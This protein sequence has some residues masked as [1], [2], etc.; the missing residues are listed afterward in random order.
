MGA[1]IEDAR[2]RRYG[3]RFSEPAPN[4]QV[5]GQEMRPRADVLLV[6]EA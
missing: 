1:Q 5:V 6:R 4:T 3:R 2:R